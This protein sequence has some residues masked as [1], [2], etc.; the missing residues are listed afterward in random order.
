VSERIAITCG[1]PAGVGPE[2]ISAWLAENPSEAG[3]VAVIGPALWL[4]TLPAGP[5]KLSVGFEGYAAEPGRPDGESSLVA[6]AALERAAD[7]CGSGE[8]DG[9]VTAPVS[10]GRMASI[11]W[12]F[13]GQTEFFAARWGGEP[14]M[15]FCGGIAASLQPW[16]R[17]SFP[18][19]LA[20]ARRSGSLLK[21]IR[22]FCNSLRAADPRAF[23]PAGLSRF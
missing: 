3:G 23:I 22:Y 12:N 2:I 20:N 18:P 10:K 16:Y 15:A 19:C 1:D 4:A 8:F 14:T 5:R 9:A 11:G 21:S 7:L 17:M 13:P 6:W